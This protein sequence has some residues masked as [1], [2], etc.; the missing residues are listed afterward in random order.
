[1]SKWCFGVQRA[2]LNFFFL[3][4]LHLSVSDIDVLKFPTM[5]SSSPCS[6]MTSLS[7]KCIHT[8]DCYASVKKMT[9]SS[10]FL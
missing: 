10:Q 6:S 2:L 3:N 9:F 5:D 4:Q 1:M 7:V 8:R